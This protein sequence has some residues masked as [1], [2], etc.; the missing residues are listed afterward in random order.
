MNSRILQCYLVIS[1]FLIFE[2][3]L[4]AANSE[5]IRSSITIK[6]DSMPVLVVTTSPTVAGTRLLG[7]RN[8]SCELSEDDEYTSKSRISSDV[9]TSLLLP[10]KENYSSDDYETKVQNFLDLTS[11]FFPAN[12][13]SID[14]NEDD[15]NSDIYERDTTYSLYS[16]S[17]T[18]EQEYQDLFPCATPPLKILK[19]DGSS[20]PECSFS[21]S[22]PTKIDRIK[23]RII[24]QPVKYECIEQHEM[25]ENMDK[26][27]ARQST[28]FSNNKKN[29]IESDD[30]FPPL[31]DLQD[32]HFPI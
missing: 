1:L 18:S 30:D 20:M 28:F 19:D 29:T 9:S 6:R 27:Y 31:I 17:S 10:S 12:T 5:T 16:A 32:F 22:S 8:R 15:E 11:P 13:D 25:S 4:Q 14:S 24:T 21:N 26:S 23:G 7:S 3:E 2:N